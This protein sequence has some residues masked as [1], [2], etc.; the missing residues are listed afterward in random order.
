MS[1]HIRRL[2]SLSLVTVIKE[3]RRN[4]YLLTHKAKGKAL[5]DSI[6]IGI[7]ELPPCVH[8]YKTLKAFLAEERA[9]P[10]FTE[11]ELRKVKQDIK[12]WGGEVRVAV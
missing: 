9:K 11:R 3:G 10:K 2:V 1:I 5:A 12:E 6:R 7:K 4:Y 8:E